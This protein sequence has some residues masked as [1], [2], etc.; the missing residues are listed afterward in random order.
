MNI[1]SK[2]PHMNFHKEIWKFFGFDSD[3]SCHTAWDFYDMPEF[4]LKYF[5]V[6]SLGNQGIPYCT[7]VLPADA[8][9]F[10]KK[11]FQ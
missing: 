9:S 2:K 1:L 10:Q 7:A 5:I 4:F 3:L 6:A 8:T 11:K